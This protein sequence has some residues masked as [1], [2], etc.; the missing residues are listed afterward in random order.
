MKLFKRDEP[1]DPLA[2]LRSTILKKYPAGVRANLFDIRA[3]TWQL[4]Y[5]RSDYLRSLRELEG[6]SLEIEPASSTSK[7]N[8]RRVIV[9]FK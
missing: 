4:P 1:Q 6:E 8:D 7:T 9:H 5:V 3:E 2:A